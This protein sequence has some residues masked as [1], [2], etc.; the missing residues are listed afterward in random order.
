M[1]QKGFV[2]ILILLFVAAAV[3][4]VG[5]GYYFLKLKTP[6]QKACTLEAKVC[7]DGTSVGRTG[8]NCEFS[9]CPASKTTPTPVSDATANWKTYSNTKY[10][11]TLKYPNDWQVQAVAAG[12]GGAE[13]GPDQPSVA[14]SKIGENHDYDDGVINIEGFQSESS[15]SPDWAISNVIIN[16]IKMVKRTKKIETSGYIRIK[17]LDRECYTFQST[18]EYMTIC[19]SYSQAKAEE[20]QTFDQIISTFKFVDQNQA[21]NSPE[22]VANNFFNWYLQCLNDH[23]Q[24]A[25]NSSPSQYNKSIDEACPYQTNTGISSKLKTDNILCSQNTPASISTDKAQV[26]GD[27]ATTSVHTFYSG[28]GDRPITVQ[29]EKENNSWRITNII[30]NR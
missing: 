4:V 7:P 16:N 24:K 8:P 10:G 23:F 3:I 5:G 26:S 6:E 13:A 21:K 9:P 15:W 18:S 20:K 30:C 11:Y 27:M 2:P 29:L 28:S 17:P 22:F 14:I 19:F 25:A 1:N 12:A